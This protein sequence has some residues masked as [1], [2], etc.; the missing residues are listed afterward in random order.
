LLCEILKIKYYERSKKKERRGWIKLG[1][2]MKKREGRTKSIKNWNSRKR[3]RN[4]IKRDNKRWK[5]MRRNMEKMEKIESRT[6]RQ[7]V[8]GK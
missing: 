5:I 7:K 4:D 2:R 8:E 6:R 1:G 3:T